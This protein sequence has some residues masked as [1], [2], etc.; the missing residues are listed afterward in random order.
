[1]DGHIPSIGIKQ[2]NAIETNLIFTLFVWACLA[3]KPY[4][5]SQR[6]IFFSYTKSVN[7]TFSHGLSAKQNQTNRAKAHGLEGAGLY[8]A[9]SQ[10]RKGSTD[11]WAFVVACCA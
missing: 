5:F 7:I 8:L 3:Y 1:M 11:G 10:E 4:F 6:T 9:Y 2:P